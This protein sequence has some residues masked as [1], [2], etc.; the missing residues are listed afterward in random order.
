M[1]DFKWLGALLLASMALSADESIDKLLESYRAESDLSKITRRDSAG[2]ISL[3][4]R[5][6]LEQM[7][8]RTLL[9]VL[10]TIPMIGLTRSTNNLTLLFKPTIALMPPSSIRLYINDHDMTS[11]SFGSAML[12]WGDMPVES[13]DH[14]EIYKGAS[15]IEFGNEPGVLVIRLYTKTALRDEGGKLKLWWGDRGSVEGSTY[16]AHTTENDIKIFGFADGFDVKSKTY[17]DAFGAIRDN[18][19][20][21]LFY[22]D[23]QYHGWRAE[24]GRYQ[25]EQSN[26]LGFYHNHDGGLD[27]EHTYIHLTKAEKDNYKIQIIL[28]YH[29]I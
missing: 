26:F 12:V 18:R 25:K 4:T 11:T 3:Y 6:D 7:Q 22:T 5:E 10:K 14:I 20:G 15:S 9:D 24:A 27:A 28:R 16:I 13:I 2:I 23:L 29:R 1:R 17:H 8:A 21:G 19:E